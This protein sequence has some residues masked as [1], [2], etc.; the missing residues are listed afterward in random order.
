MGVF[1]SKKMK[2]EIIDIWLKIGV[3]RNKQKDIEK[4][5]AI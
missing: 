5:K 4:I 1:R 3:L 2:K